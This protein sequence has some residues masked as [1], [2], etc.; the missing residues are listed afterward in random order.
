MT[1]IV[2]VFECDD[3]QY[4]TGCTSSK[5]KRSKKKSKPDSKVV[6]LVFAETFRY[7]TK[8]RKRETQI[9][10]MSRERKEK[11]FAKAASSS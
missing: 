4:Y 3:G 9:R 6:R 10:K 2:Y 1:H 11:L 8:A 5:R 7:K